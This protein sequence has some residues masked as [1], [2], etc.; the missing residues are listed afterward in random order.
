MYSLLSTIKSSVLTAALLREG[1]AQSRALELRKVALVL[2]WSAGTQ[3]PFMYCTNGS[4]A[5]LARE[6]R[7][8]GCGSRPH[9][10]PGGEAA[11]GRR[12]DKAQAKDTDAAA[13][14]GLDVTEAIVLQVR[15]LQ[16][17]G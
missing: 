7:S 11:Q 14:E 15:Q 5:T 2:W 13:A 10:Q 16:R 8:C 4:E 3:P 17:L 6:P 1:M 9:L 12:V